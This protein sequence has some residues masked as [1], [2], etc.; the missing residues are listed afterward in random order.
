MSAGYTGDLR[1]H[2]EAG[3]VVFVNDFES[4]DG[5]PSTPRLAPLLAPRSEF[6]AKRR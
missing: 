6:Y 1:D 3:G 2:P 4:R 5:E